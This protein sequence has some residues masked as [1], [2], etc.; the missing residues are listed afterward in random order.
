MTWRLIR[1]G[2]LFEGRG[3]IIKKD[4]TWGLIRNE[5]ISCIMRSFKIFDEEIM[6][7]IFYKF[8]ST[9]L[10]NSENKSILLLFPGVLNDIQWFSFTPLGAN[11]NIVSFSSFS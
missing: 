2:G 5:D 6:I 7:K 10:Y 3:L 11:S 1:G 9:V 4:F 8:Q